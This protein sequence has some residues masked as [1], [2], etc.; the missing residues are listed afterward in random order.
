MHHRR[1]VARSSH[2]SLSTCS[3]VHPKLI[4]GKMIEDTLIPE[5]FAYA[6]HHIENYFYSLIVA[7]GQTC[8]TNHKSRTA[9]VIVQLV[10]LC[11][12]P[13]AWLCVNSTCW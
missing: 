12:F 4:I 3:S 9:E 2:S 6:A 5:D 1:K 7:S 10:F 13:S 8:M 11:C